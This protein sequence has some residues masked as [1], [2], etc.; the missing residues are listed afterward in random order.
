M[1]VEIWSDI[2]CPF[3][4][5]GKAHFEK[6]LASFAS[7]ADVEVIYKSFQLDPEYQNTEKETVYTHLSTKKGMS[8]SQVTEMTAQ[9]ASM[10]A[11]TGLTID[12]DSNIPANTKDAHRLIHLAASQNKADIV[13][14]ALFE[15]HFTN[16]EDLE[17]IA[18]LK[19]IGSHCGLTEAQLDNLFTTETFAY[20]VTQDILESR[21][22]GIRGV[23]FFLF[24]RKYAV[25][26]AQPVEVFSGALGTSFSEWQKENPPLV[27]LNTTDA[28][29]CSDGGC[30]I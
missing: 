24:N 4:Y 22:L 29:I 23:P 1:K 9:V 26:G 30:E 10:A 7:K 21:N 27:S 28:G 15:A 13:L 5:I 16:G 6:A 11:Q 19:Q 17:N 20:D 2:A 18:V 14:N 25:S 3:C 12:F 8:L